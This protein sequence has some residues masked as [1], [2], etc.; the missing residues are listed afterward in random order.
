MK[1]FKMFTVLSLISCSAYSE[2]VDCDFELMDKNISNL[3]MVS[4]P[5]NT[6]K[7]GNDL[8]GNVVGYK[9]EKEEFTF[10]LAPAFIKGT[11]LSTL[12]NSAGESESLKE[13]FNSIFIRDK[14]PTSQYAKDQKQLIQKA[15]AYGVVYFP[16]GVAYFQLDTKYGAYPNTASIIFDNN[17]EQYWDI[18]SDN[19][20]AIIST[21]LK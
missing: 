20:S 5:F 11:Q 9:V 6:C 19:K 13:F 10:T 1:F 18:S 4:K 21:L 17:L 14:A 3:I 2:V 8:A 16:N 15:N 12:K 7:Q